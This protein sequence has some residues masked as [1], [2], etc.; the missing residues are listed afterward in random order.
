MYVYPPIPLILG[1]LRQAT[2]L[3]MMIPACLRQFW[4]SDLMNLSTLPHIKLLMLQYD[5]AV[6]GISPTSRSSNLP[7]HGLEPVW[8]AD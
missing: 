1:V 5:Y 7:L 6:E 3:M 8:L 2:D 4:Y